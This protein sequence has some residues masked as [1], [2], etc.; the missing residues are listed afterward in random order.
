MCGIAQ[1]II[2]SSSVTT[3]ISHTFSHYNTA[4]TIY[5]V[6][7]MS[8]TFI[9]RVFR[10]I[11]AKI[12]SNVEKKMILIVLLMTQYSTMVIVRHD[13]IQGSWHYL[14]TALTFFFLILYHNIIVG[15]CSDTLS[16][17]V[18]M[19]KKYI[20]V[21]SGILMFLFGAVQYIV[22]D[23]RDMREWW[24][25]LCVMEVF[26]VLLLGSLDVVDIYVF[27]EYIG[28]D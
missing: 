12:I 20:S 8:L 15:S 3:T 7:P 18:I 11:N 26:A 9:F 6:G 1:V 16:E 28:I 14:F 23:I 19:I 21:M 27:G 13:T 4:A 2:S 22:L 25:V 24:E 10:T 5:I 17:D